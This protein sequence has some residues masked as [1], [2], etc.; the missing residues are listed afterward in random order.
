MKIISTT[1]ACFLFGLFSSM[2]IEVDKATSQE[3]IGGVAGSGKVNEY[4]V[5]IT[6]KKNPE[7]IS[8]EGI[9]IDGHFFD[10]F[11][12]IPSENNL[13]HFSKEEQ[14][15]FFKQS[16]KGTKFTLSFAKRWKSEKSGNLIPPP[17]RNYEIPD[18]LKGKDMVICRWKQK[19]KFVEI[20]E[21]NKKETKH[22]P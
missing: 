1:V 15:S 16:E 8:L 6:I 19:K 4:R 12:I 18:D 10:D 13:K 7:K 5:E 22:M 17:K 11:K 21:V 2:P 9:I 14:K 3:V 20:P